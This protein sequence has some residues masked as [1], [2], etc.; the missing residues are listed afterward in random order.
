MKGYPTLYSGVI[1]VETPV[2]GGVRI[3]PVQADLS[4]K[5]GA[6]LKN[7]NNVKEDLARKAGALGCNCVSEFQYGQKSR[8]LAIDDVAYFGGGVATRLTPDAYRQITEYIAK[9]DS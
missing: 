3:A 1:F 8:W 9:R 7:L 6:Q 4:F 5:L 2:D